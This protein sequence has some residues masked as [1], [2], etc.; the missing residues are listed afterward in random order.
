LPGIEAHED[1][2]FF[3]GEVLYLIDFIPQP[4][5]PWPLFHTGEPRVF[6]D[7]RGIE[8]APWML[9]KG[10]MQYIDELRPPGKGDGHAMSTDKTSSIVMNEA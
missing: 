9:I 1:A 8:G 5:T 6:Y 10:F 2:N 7:H 4:K 3:A